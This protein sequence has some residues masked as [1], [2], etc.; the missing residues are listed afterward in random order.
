M[1]LFMRLFLRFIGCGLDER[2]KLPRGTLPKKFKN[3]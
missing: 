3:N 2:A 1:Q